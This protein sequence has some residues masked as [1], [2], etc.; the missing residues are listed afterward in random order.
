MKNR[1][2]LLAYARNEGYKGK[3][4]L[5][6]LRSWWVEQGLDPDDIRVVD[7]GKTLTW[8]IDDLWRIVPPIAGESAKGKSN[9]D[10]DL[11]EDAA[12]LKARLADIE[13]K[14]R[15]RDARDADDKRLGDAEDGGVEGKSK[16]PF[17]PG[18]G[19]F[20]R[21]AEVKAF[22]AK[23]ARGETKFPDADIAE[24]A[25]AHIRLCIAENTQYGKMFTA[26][27]R[28]RDEDVLK[29]ANVS[30][31]DVLG[32]YLVPRQM[33][34]YFINIKTQYGVARQLFRSVQCNDG[35]IDIAKRTSGVT[36]YSPVEGGSITKSQ[37][38]VGNVHISPKKFA[39]VTEVSPELIR[40]SAINAG[41]WVAGEMAY[42]FAKQEDLCM[43]VGDGTSTYF[44]ITGIVSAL[45]GL[46][47][48]KANI[49]GL[50]KPVSAGSWAN[51]DIVDLEALYG[52]LEDKQ[53]QLS[54]LQWLGHR[55]FF[56]EVVVRE[57]KSAGGETSMMFQGK[58]T[59]ML[60]GDPFVM[61][62]AMPRVTAAT[63]VF[64]LYGDFKSAGTIADVAG[65]QISTSEH[66]AFTADL[67]TIK[68]VQKVGFAAHDV[69][70]ADATEA[71]R[72]PG[73]VVGLCTDS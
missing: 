13:R 50:V 31:D 52:R 9:D 17:E 34:S 4:D 35:G 56:S 55:R 68:A 16:K 30:Y 65:I 7:G 32:G 26:A 5:A 12:A 46:S 61:A 49:A 8:K 11:G 53:A 64:C 25:G 47:A 67:I 45:Y 2:E 44:G 23:A 6:E 40:S 42:A 43:L 29:K 63:G 1:K 3:P 72:I 41:E 39:A 24:L 57:V 19:F 33:D 28:K 27:D 60:F 51:L 71:N 70:N 62:N 69:G 48:T 36:V 66:A 38:Q 18:A 14:T 15:E 21:S 54:N 73:P 20:G 22:N 59:P 10:D 58:P 37:A